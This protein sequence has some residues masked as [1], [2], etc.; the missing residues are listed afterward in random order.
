MVRVNINVSGV[1]Y[2][3]DK[4]LLEGKEMDT[5]AKLCSNEKESGGQLSLIVD[6]PVE[7]FA[8]ILSYYQTDELH[9]PQSV[10]PKAFKKE[11]EYWGVA[12][13]E[14]EPCCLYR[15][16]SF[17]DEFDTREK[18]RSETFQASSPSSGEIS[19][20]VESKLTR[21]RR[22]IWNV[23]DFKERTI[24]SKI[25]LAFMFI[26][27]LMC[28]LTLAL[29]TVKAFQRKVKLCEMIEYMEH[30][31]HDYFEELYDSFGKPDCSGDFYQDHEEFDYYRFEYNDTLGNVQTIQLP[32]ITVRLL[33]FD[34]LEYIAAAVFTIDLLLRLATCPSLLKYFKSILNIFDIIA[35]FAFYLQI[36]VMHGFMKHHKYKMSW[37]K[38]IGFLQLFRIMRLL[39][40]IS[41]IRASRVLTFSL[42]SNAKDMVLLVLLMLICVSFFGSLIYFVE[43]EET[44]QS[45]PEGWYWT[46][47]TITTVGY[48]D[49]TPKTAP[50]R[51][52]SSI[53]AVCG[54]LL[55]SI[56]LPMFVNNFLSLYQYS[57]M[58]ELLDK[59]HSQ[60]R[61]LKKTFEATV[62]VMRVNEHKPDS[63]NTDVEDYVELP[64][65]KNNK[66]VNGDRMATK[67]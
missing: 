67:K 38:A 22:K 54:V 18:F 27:I 21:V 11:L 25:Y 64:T 63:G 12:A 48:G 2:E 42:K 40:I 56:S 13:T 46:M 41:N 36:F 57:C 34:V 4:K 62:A 24:A 35:V 5:L 66:I 9:M 65:E 23:I 15:Y 45:V 26:M 55:L 39:R 59:H 32:D 53:L 30:S 50:G 37:I 29:S 47:I 58:D 20:S 60:Q 19:V 6:R 7:S 49:I 61:K 10:C 31:D 16:Y 3:F 1:K 43:S 8:A 44:I 17:F 51:F 14:L 28:I 52:I 33:V